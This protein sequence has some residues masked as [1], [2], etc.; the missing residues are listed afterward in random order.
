M[1]SLTRN[2]R[3][4]GSR[5]G[6]GLG[7]AVTIGLACLSWLAPNA[8]VRLNNEALDLQFRLRG[9][10][11]P[12]HNIALVLIDEKSL[13]EIGRWPWS[14]DKQSLLIERIGAQQPA[15]IGIDI[16]YAESE[17]SVDF[18]GIGKWSLDAYQEGKPGDQPVYPLR[19]RLETFDADERFANSLGRAGKIVLTLPFFVPES[20]ATAP[21]SSAIETMSE[22]LKR[23]EFMVVKQTKASEE[24]RPYEAT[25]VLPVLSQFA[26]RA[27]AL[28]HVY[29]LPDH[30]G[31]TRR[32]VLALRHGDAYVPSF[33]LEIAR[34]Y[35]G[36]PREH[37]ALVLGDGVKLGEIFV[38]TDQKLRMLVDYAG[39]DRR[40]PWVSATDV[41]H[42]RVQSDFFR[43]RVVLVGTAALGTYDQLS[44]PFSANFP[45]VEKNATVVENILHQQFLTAGLWTGP[46]EF[47]LVLLFGFGLTFTLSRMRAV[48]GTWL[49]AI[50]LL[51]YGGVAQGIFVMEGI[52]LPVVIPAST[53]GT[54]F[55]VTTVLNYVLEERQ[56]REI[57]SMFA[58]Y[59]SPRIVHELVECPSKATLGG[60]RRELTMLFVDLVGFTAYSEHRPAED[61]VEQL[62]E[63]LSAMTEVIFRWDGTLDKFVGDEIV[64]FWGAPLDQPNHAELA[65]RCALEL[66]ARLM[67][68][69]TMW[70]RQGK[71][72]LDN[73][74]GINT[75]VVVVGNIGA[76]GKK[77]DYTMI[78]DQVN[79]AARVQ[80][81]T[82]TLGHPILLTKS[83]ASRI[84][85]ALDSD[86]TEIRSDYQPMHLIP[87]KVVTVKGRQEPVA[88][89]TVAPGNKCSGYSEPEAR[90]S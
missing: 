15:V 17:D 10:R 76:E 53:I 56:A 40:F 75:G 51:G 16:I 67:D 42:Q 63:Y 28:G 88:L 24:S 80:G 50:L 9:E 54:V 11:N 58:R 90:A 48:H 71:P 41:I 46:V 43:D 57:H 33:A 6:I 85:L 87:L 18:R 2:S 8:L 65:V 83:T 27:A 23:S 13:K 39:R 55:M 60:Q 1:K 4:T 52:C 89:Y 21:F 47:G 78:G 59:V 7:A 19:N 44:T 14:R 5:F 84:G 64:V 31:V 73:G 72:I 12:G 86:S 68:L 22:A 26:S 29:R 37:M 70:K 38:P 81:L 49:A 3:E 61:V 69:Q 45:G 34:L 79:L 35:L 77:I 62:N 66:R 74:L 36:H 82:R 32:E 20:E 25:A 30:D